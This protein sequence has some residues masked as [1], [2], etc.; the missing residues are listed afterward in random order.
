MIE[1]G[2]VDVLAANAVVILCLAANQLRQDLVNEGKDVPPA[3]T[4]GPCL[5]CCWITAWW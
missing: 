5:Y 4:A 3:V 2:H 1:A